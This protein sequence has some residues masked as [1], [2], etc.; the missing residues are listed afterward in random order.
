MRGDCGDFVTLGDLTFWRSDDTMHGK[1]T[2]PGHIYKHINAGTQIHLKQH[3]FSTIHLID[4]QLLTLIEN[5]L[6]HSFIFLN[7]F[8]N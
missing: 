7:T 4:S 8:F 2:T 6:N 1:I 5:D 3:L